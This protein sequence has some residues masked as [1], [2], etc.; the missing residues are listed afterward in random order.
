MP[1]PGAVEAMMKYNEELPVAGVLLALDGL[2]SPSMGARVRLRLAELVCARRAISTASSRLAASTIQNPP[3][4]SRLS[5]SGP[6]VTCALPSCTTTRAP[7]ASCASRPP[8]K[9]GAGFVR[10]LF[11]AGEKLT[12]EPGPFLDAA[13]THL[14]GRIPLGGRIGY[15]L[16]AASTGARRASATP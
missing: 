16:G 1:D 8:V 15:G 7:A 11:P 5:A 3:M 2:H 6:F 9:K 4:A 14:V 10:Q 12:N 13:S